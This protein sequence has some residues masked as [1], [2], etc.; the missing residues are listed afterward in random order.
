M[1]GACEYSRVFSKDGT[2]ARERIL[3]GFACV[4]E[5]P[6]DGYQSNAVASAGGRLRRIACVPYA[7]H[8][9]NTYFLAEETEILGRSAVFVQTHLD[10]G[11]D[12][13]RRSQI[14]AVLRE[15][16]ACPRVVVAGDFNVSSD[17]EYGPFAAAGFE[18]AN[19]AKFGRL[20]THRRRGAGMTPAIDNVFAKGFRIADACVG[21]YALSLSDHR[22]LVVRL[23]PS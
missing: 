11:A 19:C 15:F 18:A 12:D 16:S 3:G 23:R 9:Q 2:L 17:E 10:L 20:P 21:D 8:S 4:D 14:E 7:I 13:V 22:P 5:G 1:L 6:Q